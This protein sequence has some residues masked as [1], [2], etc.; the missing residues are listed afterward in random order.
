M[1]RS[2]YCVAVLLVLMTSM[3]PRS[4]NA[5]PRSSPTYVGQ[6][7]FG[8]QMLHLEDGCL[9]IHGTVT[10]GSFFDDLKRIDNDGQ[11]EYRKHGKVVTEYPESLTTSIRISGDPCARMPQSPSAIFRGNSYSLKLEVYWK[12]GMEMRPAVLSPVLARCVGYSSITIPG[13]TMTIPSIACQLTVESRGV[14][15]VDHLIVAVFE[16]NGRPLTRI[17]AAP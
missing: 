10:A 6:V 1:S 4:A 9:S 17:S 16:A 14:P 7:D 12:R 13:E 15:L 3:L 5:R 2:R 11:L 8:P